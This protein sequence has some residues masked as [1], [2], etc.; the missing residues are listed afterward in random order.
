[1][2]KIFIA[3]SLLIVQTGFGQDCKTHAANKPSATVRF[4]DVF[5][6]AVSDTKKPAAWNITKMKPSLAKAE[7]WV[8]NIL[9]GFTGTKL[10]YCNDYFLDYNGGGHTEEFYK[11]TGIKGFYQSSMRFYAYYCYDNKDYIHTE[12]ESGSFIHVVFNNVFAAGLCSDIG[13][14][15]V[16]GKPV[17]TVYEKTRTEGRTDVYDLRAKYTDDNVYTSHNEIFVIRNSDNPVFIPV[18][19]KEY[20]QQML[21]DLEVYKI[22]QRD[23]LT[24][25]YKNNI[26][27]FEAEMKAYVKDR[28]YTQDKEAK[29]RKWFAEDQQKLD[30]TIK[31]IDTDATASREVIIQYLK[32]PAEWLNRSFRS[33]YTDPYTIIG[34]TQ[35]FDRLDIFTESSEDNTRTAVVSLNPAYFN[36]ALGTD[37]PQLILVHLSKKRYPHM[38]KVTALVKQRG[39][40]APLETL[41]NPA[42]QASTATTSQK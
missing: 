31:K 22:K 20:L 34:L 36:K 25:M 24:G 30:K 37:V 17:F 13:L 4:P 32:K 33:F 15:N 10:A 21:K 3:F 27:S 39:A 35:Y 19:R 41:L 42:N 6:A 14:F 9:N 12:A 16:N 1:M 8:K 40:L 5:V 11:A 26:T 2:K 7:S 23:M 18:T 29:R 28:N 38:L